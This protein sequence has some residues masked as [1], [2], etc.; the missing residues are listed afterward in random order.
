MAE[1]SDQVR[2]LAPSSDRP[3][4]S[5]DE[6]AATPLSVR[7]NRRRRCLRCCG[8]VAAALLI[9]A[10][11]VV[12]LVFTVF[13]TRDPVI[14]LNRAT[15]DRL[16][17]ING[18]TTPRP[19]SNMSLTADV[20]VKNPNY[21]SFRYP[22]TTTSLFYRG[23]L[24]GE[25]RGPPGNARARRTLRMNVTVDVVADRV[26]ALPDVGSDLNSGAVTISSYTEI[27]GR[28]KIWMVK[29]HATVRMNCSLT[30][31]MTSQAITEQKCK[32]KVKL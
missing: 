14:R 4:S 22:N 20:S 19:G 31:N 5:D 9:Q 16:D 7:K 28:V 10:A 23:A 32:R 15:V 29:K 8:C 30:I 26:L 27:E 11:V 2:P 25:A 21:A 13:K 3:A 18:T 24:I 12:A 1:T 6:A 17:L